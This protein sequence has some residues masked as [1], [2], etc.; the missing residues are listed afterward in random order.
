MKRTVKL[1]VLV[2]VLAL[3]GVA[4]SLP[5]WAL[6][7]CSFVSGK[8]CGPNGSTTTCDAGGGEIGE[9]K[10]RTGHWLCLL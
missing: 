9:C 4:A 5:A 10:C 7:P 8:T 2:A 1:G 6:N 3:S